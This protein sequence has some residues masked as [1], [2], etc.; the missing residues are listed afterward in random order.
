MKLHVFSLAL[1]YGFCNR[2]TMIG[3]RT[4][5]GTARFLLSFLLEKLIQIAGYH[6]VIELFYLV[7]TFAV[8]P[9]KILDR[10]ENIYLPRCER[11]EGSSYIMVQR[12]NFRLGHQPLAVGGIC[13]N[14]ATHVRLFYFSCI[15]FKYMKNIRHACPCGIR[16]GYFDAVIVYVRG[17]SA[18]RRFLYL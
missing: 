1:L 10:A 4:G 12:L 8:K 16:F 7:G 5:A 6:S 3:G 13:D 15:I 9:L 2:K 17:I 18:K 14:T 11:S